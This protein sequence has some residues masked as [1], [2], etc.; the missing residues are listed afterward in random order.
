MKKY[1]RAIYTV[2]T[3]EYDTLQSPEY[4]DK[5]IDYICI[6]DCEDDLPSPWKKIYCPPGENR[7]DNHMEQRAAKIMGHITLEAYDQVLYH[8][9]NLIQK[10]SVIPLFLLFT[11]SKAD[12]VTM[13][14]PH[15]FCVYDEI[16]ACINLRKATAKKLI[17][18][19]IDYRMEGIPNNIGLIASGVMVR[20]FKNR[21]YRLFAEKWYSELEA[22]T[23]RDQIA[24]SVVE[25]RKD[26][27][28][29]KELVPWTSV[30]DGQLFYRVDHKIKAL[31]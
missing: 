15:R 29:T 23:H 11:E 5:D 14:H 19:H 22:H 31:Y 12:V 9:A 25:Y 21:N 10:S 1:K 24:F 2:L 17:Q 6:S 16:E 8:D 13:R 3:G 18:Q 4:V 20:S 7:L 26:P 28:I 30:L 27:A